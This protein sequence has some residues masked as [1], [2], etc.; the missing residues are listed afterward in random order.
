MDFGTV[1]TKLDEGAYANLEQFE[2][3]T[4]AFIISFFIS[5]DTFIY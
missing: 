5:V 4:C 2:V 3:R 1:R